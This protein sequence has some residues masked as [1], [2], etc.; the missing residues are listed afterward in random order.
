MYI[1]YKESASSAGDLGLLPRLRRSREKRM[2]THT[3]IPVLRIPWTEE[4]GR[5]ESMG[6]QRV[7]LN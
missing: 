6:S 5:L 3:S 2:A 1:V 4:H 7:G